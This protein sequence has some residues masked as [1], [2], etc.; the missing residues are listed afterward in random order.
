MAALFSVIRVVGYIA[1]IPLMIA[2]WK[3]I[4]YMSEKYPSATPGIGEIFSEMAPWGKVSAVVVVASLIIGVVG[5]EALD[6]ITDSEGFTAQ[7]YQLYVAEG[8]DFPIYKSPSTG[9]QVLGYTQQFDNY[10]LGESQGDF[11]KIRLTDRNITGWAKI[12]DANPQALPGFGKETW[13]DLKAGFSLFVSTLSFLEIAVDAVV[14][15]LFMA[16]LY[17]LF[18][19][20]RGEWIDQRV[21]ILMMV[22]TATSIFLINQAVL[23]DPIERA[24]HSLSLGSQLWATAFPTFFGVGVGEIVY[25]N[26]KVEGVVFIIGGFLA[27]FIHWFVYGKAAGIF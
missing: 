18:G 20:A 12:A 6:P 25:S 14:G 9:S 10:Q 1:I 8:S 13:N 4:K 19:Y 26:Q 24:R 23:P 11:I 3:V 16:V 7:L 22:I 2:L 17:R 5:G 27:S 15:V 21:N